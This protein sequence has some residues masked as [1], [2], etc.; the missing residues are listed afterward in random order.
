[1]RETCKIL[2][3]DKIT[4]SSWLQV[5]SS[6]QVLAAKVRACPSK[7]I[8]HLL[9][10]PELISGMSVTF[11]DCVI[12]TTGLYWTIHLLIFLK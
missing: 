7:P 12:V 11:M 6:L 1:V 10:K 3:S 8:F 9:F 2:S 4:D 5:T